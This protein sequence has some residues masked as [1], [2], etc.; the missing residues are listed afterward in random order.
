[1]YD[2]TTI[3]IK[4]AGRTTEVMRYTKGDMEEVFN[5]DER[6]RLAKGKVI[7]RGNCSYVSGDALAEI[8]FADAK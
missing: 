5:E 8:A 2:Y 4:E 1:M 3:Y 6:A 7:W